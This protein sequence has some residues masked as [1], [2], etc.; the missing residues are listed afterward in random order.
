MEQNW[1]GLGT[2][3][4]DVQLVFAVAVSMDGERA[5]AVLDEKTDHIYPSP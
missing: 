3:W 2:N 4:H 1:K 5:A